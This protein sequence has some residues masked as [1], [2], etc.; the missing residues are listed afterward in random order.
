MSKLKYY[1]NENENAWG[2]TESDIPKNM[3]ERTEQE[4][5]E[6]L[7]N[8]DELTTTMYEESLIEYNAEVARIIGED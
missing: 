2:S 3:H 8:Y 5:Q 1:T 7:D 6:W 4:Y